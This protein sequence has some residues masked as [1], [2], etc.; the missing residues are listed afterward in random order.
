LNTFRLL[1]T[2]LA[3]LAAS[4]TNLADTINGIDGQIRQ[5]TGLDEK[6][7]IEANGKARETICQLCGDP[8][9]G[10]EGTVHSLCA[11]QEHAPGQPAAVPAS[12]ETE[13][14]SERP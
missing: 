9:P 7:A 2:A 11:A 4:L 12:P 6:P 8:V 10:E 1:L 14:N 5:R 13:I 3:Q